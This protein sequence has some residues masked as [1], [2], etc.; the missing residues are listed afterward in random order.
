MAHAPASVLEALGPALLFDRPLGL[1]TKGAE[2]AL[3][4]HRSQSQVA[5][6]SS[7]S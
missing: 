2:Q 4:R 6:N 1:P 7:N 5:S 3:A